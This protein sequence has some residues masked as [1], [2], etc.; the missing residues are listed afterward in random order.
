MFVHAKG[1]FY[2]YSRTHVVVV[3]SLDEDNE[4]SERKKE[5]SES[6]S[7]CLHRGGSPLEIGD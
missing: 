7:D 2:L 3:F 1:F 6:V 5:G 4:E